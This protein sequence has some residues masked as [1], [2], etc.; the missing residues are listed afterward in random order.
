MTSQF[1]ALQVES[2][3]PDRVT[4]SGWT[5]SFHLNVERQMHRQIGRISALIPRSRVWFALNPWIDDGR[6]CSTFIRID[7]RGD[8]AEGIEARIYVWDRLKAFLCT[9]NSIVEL[10]TNEKRLEKWKHLRQAGSK[11][12]ISPFSRLRIFIAQFDFEWKI[13]FPSNNFSHKH[14][15]SISMKNKALKALKSC[16]DENQL[17]L[18]SKL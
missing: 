6:K 1:D 2:K 17:H 4:T 3:I 7:K 10:K 12:T 14:S 11:K 18:N 8:I 5:K 9:K 13:D 16:V 15:K